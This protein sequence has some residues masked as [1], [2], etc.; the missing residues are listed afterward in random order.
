[1]GWNV[2]Y[3]RVSSADQNTERQLEEV[4]VTFDKVFEDKASG[5]DLARPEFEK[6]LSALRDGD[7]VYVHSMDRLARTLADL[8]KTVREFNAKGVTVRF[9]KEGLAFEPE[10][11]VSPIAT[12]TLQLLGA[13][14]Q[15]ERAMIRERQR[16]GIEAAKKRGNVYKGGERKFTT[17]QLV[18]ARQRR[19]AGEAVSKIAESMG[20]SRQTLY[21][22][23]QEADKAEGADGPAQVQAARAKPTTRKASRVR[24]G[25]NG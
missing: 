17:A 25:K 13:F 2:A 6:M 18:E 21:L 14:A 22:R 12:L 23:L 16:E 24:G 4:G 5:K 10:K 9:L 19:D 11:A 8:E 1:M 3:K 7:T 15:F 20:F